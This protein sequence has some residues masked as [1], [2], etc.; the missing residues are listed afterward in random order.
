MASIGVTIVQCQ[1]VSLPN[2]RVSRPAML[3][4]SPL[5]PAPPRRA[6]YL[7]RRVSPRLCVAPGAVKGAGVVVAE[8]AE[9]AAEGEV[10]RLAPTASSE[11]T[12]ASSEA[13]AIQTSEAA[14]SPEAPA[15][16]ETTASTRPAV[17]ASSGGKRERRRGGDGKARASKSSK[18]GLTALH[19]VSSGVQRT[20]ESAGDAFRQVDWVGVGG[21]SVSAAAGL[22]AVAVALQLKRVARDKV[23]PTLGLQ[24][25][26][27]EEKVALSKAERAELEQ[28]RGKFQQAL[29]RIRWFKK[30]VEKK[31]R[32]LQERGYMETS[33][34]KL[35][36]ELAEEKTALR[37]E[38]LTSRS[39]GYARYEALATQLEELRVETDRVKAREAALRAELQGVKARQ[40]AAFM[41]FYDKNRDAI[42]AELDKREGARVRRAQ[43]QALVDAFAVKERERR[44][45]EEKRQHAE[46]VRWSAERMDEADRHKQRVVQAQ[47]S[48]AEKLM[49]WSI[50]T[51]SFGE[52][53]HERI[54][55][56]EPVKP[57]LGES[58]SREDTVADKFVAKLRAEARA[59][60]EKRRAREAKVNP[61]QTPDQ[62]P[63]QTPG[64]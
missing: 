63:D 6:A 43:R 19:L 23:L 34:A 57:T 55:M 28:L 10:P 22:V 13:T 4:V 21:V 45:E 31:D 1:G 59:K 9:G 54:E 52:G 56:P 48:A 40:A 26:L 37:E 24:T 47:L 25:E 50:P 8:P 33:E 42:Q 32:L 41:L 44:W 29:A 18:R 2:C 7:P 16:S 53:R 61:N 38:L 46:R 17:K 12:G 11:A 35:A 15:A 3:A 30:Q 27:T 58:I 14:V 62:T 39:E 49:E 5:A 60:S 51:H 36:E 20:V 64:P